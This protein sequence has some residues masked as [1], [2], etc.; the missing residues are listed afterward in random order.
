M[1]WIEPTSVEHT[2][3]VM[4]HYIILLPLVRVRVL[5]LVLVFLALL[6]L[7]Y[8]SCILYFAHHQ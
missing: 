6:L 2:V 7:F 1:F 5:V 4:L 8:T 3:L